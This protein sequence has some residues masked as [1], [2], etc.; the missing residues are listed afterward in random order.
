MAGP[1]VESGVQH[2]AEVERHPVAHAAL[3]RLVAGE[4]DL[5]LRDRHSVHLAAEAQVGHEAGAASA[6]P[7]VQQPVVG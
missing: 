7:A 6:A 4:R 1:G 2:V 3:R 5:L